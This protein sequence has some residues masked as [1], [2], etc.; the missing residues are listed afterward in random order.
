MAHTVTALQLIQ[1]KWWYWWGRE[2]E[3]YN[4]TNTNSIPQQISS[5]Y[6]PD[7]KTYVLPKSRQRISDLKTYVLPLYHLFIYS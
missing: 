5:K 1:I 6:I 7:L 2:T 3:K 4:S